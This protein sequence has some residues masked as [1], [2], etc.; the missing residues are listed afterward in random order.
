MTGRVAR[1]GAN[2]R[3]DAMGQP[4]KEGDRSVYPTSRPDAVVTS[5]CAAN[6]LA[7]VVSD[8]FPLDKMNDAFQAEW[9]GKQTSV[10]RGDHA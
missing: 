7:S 2:V 5:V 8:R 1:L 4:L 10:P 6:S 9:E 3:T